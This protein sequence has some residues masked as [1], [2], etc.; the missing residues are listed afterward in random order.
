MSRRYLGSNAMMFKI[1]FSDA[2]LLSMSVMLSSMVAFTA[3]LPS[4]FVSE[5]KNVT[6][7]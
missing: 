5:S 6:I 3:A 7:D 4:G 1:F 2:V